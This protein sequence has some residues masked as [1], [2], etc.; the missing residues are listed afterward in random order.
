LNDVTAV[1][2]NSYSNQGGWRRQHPYRFVWLYGCD[3]AG[4]TRWCEAFGVRETISPQ[5]ANA[6]PNRVQ[7]FVGWNGTVPFPGRLDTEGWDGLQAMYANFFN[8]WT[9][10]ATLQTCIA[11]A[12]DPNLPWSLV[13]K[14]RWWHLWN[15]YRIVVNGYP[16]I[17]RLGHGN[18]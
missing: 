17:T 12:S 1:L 8:A 6:K 14:F 11:D 16:G 4:D 15:N 7:A 3:T 9:Q 10:G 5:E 13:Q 18:P 2:G